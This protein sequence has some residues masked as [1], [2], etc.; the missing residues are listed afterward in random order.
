M[1][2]GILGCL[3]GISRVFHV[4]KEALDGVSWAFNGGRTR[5]Q[6]HL[7]GS[8]DTRRSIEDSVNENVSEF[9]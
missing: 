9:I 3:K 1:L 2:Q 7:R 5:S 6:G 4:A 8:G